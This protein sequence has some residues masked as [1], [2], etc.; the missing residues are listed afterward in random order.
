MYLFIGREKRGEKGWEGRNAIS[1]VSVTLKTHL[2]FKESVQCALS[3]A[4]E[5]G[6][7]C[8]FKSSLTR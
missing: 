2:A 4:L 7:R 3:V 6:L 1:K 5:A 8:F